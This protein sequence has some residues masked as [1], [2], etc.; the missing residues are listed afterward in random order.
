MRQILASISG[1]IASSFALAQGSCENL[2]ALKLTHTTITL[3]KTIASGA[4][5]PPVSVPVPPGVPNPDYGGLPAFCRIAASIKPSQ[6]SDIRIEV[7][8]PLSHWNGKLEGVGNGGWLGAISY[9]QLVQALARGYAVASTNT[10]HEGNGLDASFAAGHPEK[11]IDFGYRSVHEMTV[12][13][14]AIV[15]S[16]YGKAARQSYWSGCSAGGRQGLQEAQRYPL[17]YDGIVAGAPAY[18]WSHTMAG[19]ASSAKAVN[20]LPREQLSLLHDA[21][22]KA[23]DVLDGVRDGVIENPRLCRFDPALLRCENADTFRCLTTT[24]VQAADAMYQGSINP[25][26]HR[27]IFPGLELGS[28]AN[29]GA[30][31]VLGKISE[32]YFRYRVWEDP[33]WELRRLKLDEDV[34]LADRRDRNN[35][36]AKESNLRRF[37]AHRGKVILYHGWADAVIAPR[38]S[39]NYYADVIAS[40][41]N[42]ETQRSVRLFMV[43]GMDHCGGGEGADEFDAF[44]ALEAWVE[45]GQAPTQIMA[46]RGKNDRTRLLCAYPGSAAYNGAGSTDDAANFSCQTPSPDSAFP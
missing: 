1:L 23:C 8:L 42:A 6:D 35:L 19:L 28:E 32:S 43:P 44:T 29:W 15:R 17:D 36:N 45:Q 21:V 22:L 18:Y 13:A 30:L 5:S 39:I 27:L 12:K 37:V 14:K 40:M 4:F 2:A 26:T 31:A 10:G 20:E 9:P 11:V 7:W 33:S 16:Y 3:A 25:R 41:G 46:R 38:S 24:Q 34:A